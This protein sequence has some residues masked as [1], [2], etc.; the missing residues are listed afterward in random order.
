MPDPAAAFGSIDLVARAETST[1]SCQS[2]PATEREDDAALPQRQRLRTR[3]AAIMDQEIHRMAKPRACR[4]RQHLSPPHY[5]Q[6][7]LMQHAG[8][9]TKSTR[10]AA[11]RAHNNTTASNSGWHWRQGWIRLDR[12][13]AARARMPHGPKTASTRAVVLTGRRRAF[14]GRMPVA[15]SRR[16]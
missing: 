16:W 15:A 13:A 8:S 12:T 9:T 1:G 7:T 11:S 10:Q 2:L 14:A 3:G 6:R 5:R 4:I